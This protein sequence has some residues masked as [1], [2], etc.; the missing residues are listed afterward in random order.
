M[1]ARYG[2]TPWRLKLLAG[3]LDALRLLKAAGCKRVFIDGSFV[4]SKEVP[5][6]FDAC[7]DADGVDFDLID[8]RLLTFDRG[9]ATQ[10]AAF[11]GEFFVADSGADPQGTLFR[12]F[13]Q[14]DREGRRKGIVVID[15]KDL[16]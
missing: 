14:T 10:K 9:R 13:F 4:T 11:M 15:L 3:M 7:W 5:G 16:P 1:L 2:I 8:E 6:D 12:D